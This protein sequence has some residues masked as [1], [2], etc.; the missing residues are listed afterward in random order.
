MAEKTKA[1]TDWEVIEYLYHNDPYVHQGFDKL[2]IEMKEAGR[3]FKLADL[4]GLLGCPN[5]RRKGG[6]DGQD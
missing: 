1:A 6:R 5:A 3:D 4:M 2:V